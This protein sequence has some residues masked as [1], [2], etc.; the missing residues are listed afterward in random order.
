MREDKGGMRS[1]CLFLVHSQRL[2][3]MRRNGLGLVRFRNIS[4]N[5][6]FFFIVYL[7]QTMPS[8]INSTSVSF[9]CFYQNRFTSLS[10]LGL[11]T[12]GN[13]KLFANLL[14]FGIDDI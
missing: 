14:H 2:Q 7:Q 1:S 10:V 5:Q 6:S 9:L 3:K 12:N 8:S 4:H 13:I 11:D